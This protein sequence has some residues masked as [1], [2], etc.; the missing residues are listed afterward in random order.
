MA[1]AIRRSAERLY[2]WPGLLLALAAV[3][4]AG[5]TVAGRLAVGQ[6]S[7]FELVFLRWL[8]V[9][10]LLW[11]LYGRQVR[12]HWRE[13]RPRLMGIVVLGTLGFT[14]FNA[15]YYVAAHYTS[16][17]NIG[18]LQ[19]S[20]PI[21]VLAGA[22][23]V[24]GTR[25]SLLQL[26][27]VLVTAA[28]VLVVATSGAPFSILDIELNKGD[29]AML[30]ACALQA[31]YTVALHDRPNMPAAAFFT[32]LALIAAVTSLPLV[33]LEAVTSGL[34]MPTLEGLLIAAWV[35]VFPS[36][37]SQ[38][39]FL[40]GVDL[41]GPG[42]AGV[43]INLV[44]VFSAVLAVTLINEPFAPYHALALALVIGGIWLAQRTRQAQPCAGETK[45]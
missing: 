2:G 22:F 21:F 4:W 38:I 6:I 40:R 20:I 18:I 39:F 41:I 25:A 24:H 15:F 37:L 35:G 8:L 30:V 36:F 43:F 16:A 32:L 44:P 33:A 12:A 23:L 31:G 45:A 14:G 11:P 5:N 3:F 34:K 29:L 10:A 9:L 26:A 42:R 1:G 28:G 17:I 27:G 13:L 7:A 19:G